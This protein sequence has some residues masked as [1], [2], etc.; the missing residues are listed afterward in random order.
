MIAIRA[1]KMGVCG[2]ARFVF[3]E[4]KVGEPRRNVLR[5]NDSA[6]SRRGR[7]LSERSTFASRM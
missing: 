7:T 2:L 5:M 4:F 6:G 3:Q 1:S